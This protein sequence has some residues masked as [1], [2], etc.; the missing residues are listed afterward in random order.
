MDPSTKLG[1]GFRQDAEKYSAYL[2][3]PEGRL[4]TDLAFAGL[5]EFLPVPSSIRPLRALDIG[6]GTG[7]AAVRLAGLGAEV[8]LLDSSAAMLEMA[9]LTASEAGFTGDIILRC[10]DAAEAGELFP[11]DSF[12]V[13]LCH[14]VLEYVDDPDA[15][16]AGAARLLRRDSPSLIS[17]LVRNRAGEV[18]KAA[19]QAGDLVSAER[20]LTAGCVV[21]SLYGGQV[22]LFTPDHFQTTFEE[23]SLDVIAR[24]GVRVL[25]DYLP[26]KIDREAEYE[27]IFELERKLGG[28]PEFAAV[29][30]YTHHLLRRKESS[31]E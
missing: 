16:I 7:A 21:E 28:R 5:R 11:G 29:A 27:Q 15:V 12:D 22:R 9:K 8:T 30:R 4:R 6:G 24:R 19:I 23:A 18:L 31:D 17:I 25:A 14:N 26:S 13:V 1:E 3:T 2:E 10:G 20:A